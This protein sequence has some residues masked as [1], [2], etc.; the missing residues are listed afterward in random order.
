MEIGC[1][2]LRKWGGGRKWV[3]YLNT[4]PLPCGFFFLPREISKPNQWGV[5][6]L[7]NFRSCGLDLI[8]RGERSEWMSFECLHGW[9]MIS[10]EGQILAPN[11]R[12]SSK[13]YLHARPCLSLPLCNPTLSCRFSYF[14]CFCTRHLESKVRVWQGFV[15]LG[16]CMWGD[17]GLGFGRR[18]HYW[19]TMAT[20]QLRVPAASHPIRPLEVTE[21]RE[22]E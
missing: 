17:L 3:G 5:S 14:P 13:N 20:S 15:V 6:F 2:K 12:N 4:T 16:F 1:T 9:T 21:W 10:S 18:L 7:E 11:C 8:A 22:F 19:M